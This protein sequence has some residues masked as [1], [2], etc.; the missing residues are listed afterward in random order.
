V[1]LWKGTNGKSPESLSDSDL[2][3][4]GIVV[5]KEVVISYESGMKLEGLLSSIVREGEVIKFMSFSKAK[6]TDTNDGNKVLYKPSW[7]PFELAMGMKIVSVE[8]TSL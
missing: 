1:G 8:T 5:G 2:S 6:V 4:M 3:G 7:G